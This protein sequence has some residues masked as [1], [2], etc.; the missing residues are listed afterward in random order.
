MQDKALE[1]MTNSDSTTRDPSDRRRFFEGTLAEALPG[2]GTAPAHPAGSRWVVVLEAEMAELGLVTFSAPRPSQ[3]LLAAARERAIEATALRRE[4]IDSPHLAPSPRGRVP[5]LSEPDVFAFF[6]AAVACIVLSYTAIENS[7]TET[8]PAEFQMRH[9]TK[10]RM[11][12]REDYEERTGLE[13]RLSAGMAAVTGRPNV[14]MA[15]PRL[16]DSVMALKAMREAV[17]HLKAS[18]VS[19]VHSDRRTIWADLLAIVDYEAE[20]VRVAE[21]VI[22]H[23]APDPQRHDSPTSDEAP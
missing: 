4:L 9:P 21:A 6:Q 22:D 12:S 13:L 7:T 3:L 23:Y 17:G 1:L 16:W 2:V 11:L 19:V 8:V 18:A 15:D 20:V 10:N 14:R 5:V